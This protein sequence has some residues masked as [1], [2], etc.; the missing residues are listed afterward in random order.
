MLMPMKT[1]G[2][3]PMTVCSYM[4]LKGWVPPLALWD[5][6]ASLEKTLMTV[7]WM[8]WGLNSRS[9]QISAWGKMSS[10]IQILTSLG[11]R[12]LNRFTLRREQSP[13]LPDTPQCPHAMAQLQSFLRA[14]TPLGLVFSTPCLFL[15]LLA[16]VMSLWLSLIPPLALWSPLSTSMTIGTPPTWWWQRGW[17]AQSLVPICMEC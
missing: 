13:L 2:A 17:S 11:L 6:V 8:H 1:K 14:P 4:I 15:T 3:R 9:W 5:V 10:H 16:M 12:A 7:S